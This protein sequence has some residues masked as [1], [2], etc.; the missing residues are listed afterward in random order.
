[1]S[2]CKVSECCDF[3]GVSYWFAL[4]CFFFERRIMVLDEECG[5]PC[6]AAVILGFAGDAWRRVEVFS[7]TNRIKILRIKIHFP[8]AFVFLLNLVQYCIELCVQYCKYPIASHTLVGCLRL[9]R[10]QLGRGR[11]LYQ[12]LA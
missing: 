9:V 12:L 1:M 5:F 2:K 10:L 11:L 3:V 4:Y 8:T 6:L 7:F